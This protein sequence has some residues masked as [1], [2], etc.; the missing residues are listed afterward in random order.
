MRSGGALFPN[1]K[2]NPK[3]PDYD[4]TLELDEELIN[5]IYSK[6]KKNAE[7]I[8]LELSGWKRQAQ[9]SGKSYLSLKPSIPYKERGSNST[10]SASNNTDFEDEIPF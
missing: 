10:K 7:E 3:A 4:G 1:N 2:T 5:Y 6:Y 8:K 9:K